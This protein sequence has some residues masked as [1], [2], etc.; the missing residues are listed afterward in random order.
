MFS[1]QKKIPV[2]ELVAGMYVFQLDRPW[3]GTP[4]PLQG[5]HIKDESD[6]QLLRQYCKTV[7]IDITRSDIRKNNLA[8]KPDKTA[9]ITRGKYHSTLELKP[10]VY[11]EHTPLDEEIKRARSVYKDLKQAVDKITTALTH[12]AQI[13]IPAVAKFSNKVVKSVLKNPDA[14]V[15][16]MKL[17]HQTT[18]IYHHAMN[19]SVWAAVLGREIG[20]KESRLEHLTTG[21]LLSKIGLTMLTDE[22][23]EMPFYEFQLTPHY[24]RHIDF[25]INLLA[26]NRKLP[27]PVIDTV[28]NHEERYDGSGFPNELEGDQIPL[29]AQI[30]GIVDTYESMLNPLMREVP[31]SPSEAVSEL[32]NMRGHEFD[33]KLVES[34]IQVI[35]LF[36]PGTLVELNTNELAIV[37]RADR[38]KRLQPQLLVVTNANKEPKK[39]PTT[40]DIYELNATLGKKHPEK[41]IEIKKSYPAG[42]FGIWPHQYKYQ[43]DSLLERMFS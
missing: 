4:F 7:V 6:I 38:D 36:P 12:N 22:M 11:S 43:Q 21:V 42:S 24:F 5:F 2:G 17:K 34:F 32:Y 13:D 25:A 35:G 31:L 23:A 39:K 30:A 19:C 20:L 10:Y 15:W 28:I 14:L 29:Y 1:Y 37:T 18:S 26:T 41:T 16:V 40:L 27:K 9:A 8:A 33:T 3:N